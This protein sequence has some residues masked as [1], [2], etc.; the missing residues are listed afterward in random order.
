MRKLLT[1][2]L[3][4][5]I[6]PMTALGADPVKI[7]W[8]TTVHDFGTFNEDL[9]PVTHIFRGRNVGSD[10]AIVTHLSATCG[11]TKPVATPRVIAPG[12]SVA[13]SVTY[14]P[15][16]RPGAF[17]KTVSFS[18]VPAG[19]G[20]G[21]HH[22]FEIKGRV[23]TSTKRLQ[24]RYPVEVGSLYRIGQSSLPFGNIVESRSARLTLEGY[25][26]SSRPIVPVISYR[27]DFVAAA[28][29]PDTVAPGKTFVVELEAVGPKIGLLGI[30]T[31][32]LTL[33]EASGPSGSITLPVSI[34]LY[35][36]FGELTA[37]DLDRAPSLECTA[38]D[39]SFGTGIDPASRKGIKRKATVT[40]TGLTAAII[41]RAYTLTPGIRVKAPSKPIEPGKSAE[42]EIELIPAELPAGTRELDTR[43]SVI[44]TS[45]LNTILDLRL[46]ATLK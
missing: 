39:I 27:P 17:N 1:A 13:L 28:I 24:R 37:A 25:N 29:S 36:D 32:S 26:S 7:I 42:I 46:T 21:Y 41:R 30:T 12:D 5:A 11:C 19:K 43:V 14:D 15:A 18:A 6:A 4:L 22:R 9:G 44:S 2:L 10:T 45:P 34:Y 38:P 3:L 8:D 16:R 20:Q 35:E 23:I 31:D 33:S 40:N